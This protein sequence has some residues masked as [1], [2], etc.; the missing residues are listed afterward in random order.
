MNPWTRKWFSANQA[1]NGGI[2]RRNRK[3]VEKYSNL[4]VVIAEAKK[5]GWHVIETGN[6]I[7]LLCHEGELVIH[8]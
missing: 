1:N 4:N 7:V 8:C 3:N 6:Q 2:I 5:R